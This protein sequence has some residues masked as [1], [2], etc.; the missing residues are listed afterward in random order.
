MLVTILPLFTHIGFNVLDLQ[1]TT[2]C[3]NVDDVY[4]PVA[5]TDIEHYPTSI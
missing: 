2:Q 4:L 1:V 3:V 5:L